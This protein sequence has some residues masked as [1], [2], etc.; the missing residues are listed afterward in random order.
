MK[1]EPASLRNGAPALPFHRGYPDANGMF[2]DFGGSFIPDAL[3]E[4]MH[5]INE[6]YQRISRSHDFIAELRRI[7]KHYQG[8]PTPVYYARNISEEVGGGRIYLKREDLNH[9]GAHK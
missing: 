4:Q 2:G 5:K 6:A 9:S 3:I 1:T 8:R 7:R